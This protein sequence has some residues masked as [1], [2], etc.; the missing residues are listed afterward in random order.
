MELIHLIIGKSGPQ[1][2]EALSSSFFVGLAKVLISD[3]EA[4]TREMSVA[5][6]TSIFEKMGTE[7][8]EKY[9][10][11]WMNS[12]NSALL[13]CSLQLYRIKLKV[14]MIDK[15]N[16]KPVDED[17]LINIKDILERS[18][19]DS[20]IEVSWEL[21]YSALNC[22]IVI[23]DD[24]HELIDEDLKDHIISALLY[25]HSW[26][27]LVSSRLVSLLI[28]K[29]NFFDASDI[30]NIS[31]RLLH[32]LRA[33]MIEE[34]LGA[35]AIKFLTFALMKWEKEGIYF[36]KS[37]IHQDTEEVEEEGVEDVAKD[38]DEIV[39]E[40]EE[41]KLM[42]DWVIMKM[43]SIIRSVR[44]SHVAKKSSIQFLALSV[45][46]MEKAQVSSISE[47][48][49]FPLFN[50]SDDDSDSE[51]RVELRNLSLECLNMIK[52][53]I[54]VSEYTEA[55]SKVR[56]FI[57]KRRQERRTKR[58]VLAIT[59]PEAAARRKIKKHSKIREKRKQ[60]KDANGLYHTKKKRTK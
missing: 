4:K 33:P 6:I 24:N 57:L 5:L 40:T 44:V 45:Q 39:E 2:L 30:Q 47:T 34:S 13:K 48:L 38:D 31:N 8:Y 14:S 28:S 53:K 32:Q 9:I 55:Y 7:Q 52:D 23:V 49:I 35:Q 25:P 42:R 59:A 19:S 43:S 50:L 27:R 3:T 21:I 41:R 54:G 16:L 11:G 51:P 12:K 36:D 15:N 60:E 58:S 17:V 46:I 20:E 22:L 18:R 37:L 29:E 10:I 1:L 26:I 56:T